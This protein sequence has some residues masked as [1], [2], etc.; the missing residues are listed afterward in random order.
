MTPKTCN[1]L[2]AI[3]I[4]AVCITNLTF[5]EAM[6]EKW[7]AFPQ[8]L[9]VIPISFLFAFLFG[10]VH[11]YLTQAPL[12]NDFGCWYPFAAAVLIFILCFC[13][14]AYSFY[15]YIVWQKVTIWEAA[16]ARE[17]LMFIFFGAVVVFPTIIAY[18]IFSYK[19]FWGKAT[20]LTY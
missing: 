2:M 13:G 1:I 15:P 7:F 5:N 10:S 11:I 18:T 12:K 9:V 14:L 16:S 8:L 4:I 19:V 20:S 17:S 6:A 3:G